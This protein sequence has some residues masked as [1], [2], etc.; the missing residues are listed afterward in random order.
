VE[1]TLTVIN[2]LKEK[3]IIEDYAIGGGIA[4]IYH[5]EPFL[6]Y[7]LD[8]FVILPETSNKKIIDLRMLFSELSTKGYTWNKE[9]IIVEGVPV[10]FIPADALE[11]KRYIMP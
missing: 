3:G 5:I 1:K 2:G 10:Q 11:T 7:D 6:T 8:I 4:A 9:H